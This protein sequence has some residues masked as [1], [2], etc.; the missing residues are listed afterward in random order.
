MCKNPDVNGSREILYQESVSNIESNNLHGFF[1]G[2]ATAP[3]PETL[4]HLL[5]G[6]NYVVLAMDQSSSAVVGFVTALSDG[7][8]SAYIPL[9]EVLPYYRGRGIGTE[10]INRI[11]GLVDETYMVD[12]ICDSQLENFYSRLGF[13][14]AFGMSIRRYD[15]QDGR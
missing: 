9:L 5:Q 11:L 14:A 12:L 15:R 3:S 8:L 4:L 13:H 10:L 6:S 2:W 7:V 1:E